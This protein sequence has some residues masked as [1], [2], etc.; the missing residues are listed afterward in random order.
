[1]FDE[2]QEG[3]HHAFVVNGLVSASGGLAGVRDESDSIA[4]DASKVAILIFAECVAK[5][6]VGEATELERTPDISGISPGI[7]VQDIAQDS[8]RRLEF[9]WP[10][11]LMNA[12][13]L[14]SIVVR[15]R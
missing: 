3:R 5:D 6:V 10:T 14:A 4:S 13:I 1:M 8:G 11:S 9:S 15:G 7:D 2:L 12:L